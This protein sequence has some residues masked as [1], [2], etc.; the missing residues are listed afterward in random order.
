MAFSHVA[1]TLVHGSGTRLYEG[2]IVANDGS[3]LFLRSSCLDPGFVHVPVF[4][5][6]SFQN[7]FHI[8]TA[9]QAVQPA[10]KCFEWTV[11]LG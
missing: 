8:I 1:T 6:L 7:K 11:H 2:A 4:S 3:E 5:P 10:G 9:Y